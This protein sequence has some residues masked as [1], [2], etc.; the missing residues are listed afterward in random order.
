MAH[1]LL[2]AELDKFICSGIT[3]GRSST[4]AL[5]DERVAKQK[6]VAR[7]EALARLAL[8]YFTSHGPATLSDF[9]WWSGLNMGDARMALYMVKENLVSERRGKETFWFA[10]TFRGYSGQMDSVHL[11]PAFDEFI[12]SYKDRSASLSERINGKAVSSNGIFRPVILEDGKV[13]G[14]WKRIIKNNKL[15]LE[16]EFFGKPDKSVAIK[17]DEAIHRYRNF[18]GS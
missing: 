6:S 9:N 10:E 5:F 17:L 18:T 2:Y 13:T 4:Y 11:L 3:R 1:L 14:L 15:I 7:S 8:R 16:T 12:I